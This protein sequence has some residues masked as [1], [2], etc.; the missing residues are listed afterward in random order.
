MSYTN[1][2]CGYFSF[3]EGFGRTLDVGG[4]FVEFNTSP[5]AAIADRVAIRSDWAAVG[6][7]LWAALLEAQKNL[8]GATGGTQQATKAIA[9]KA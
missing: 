2:L 7:D 5:T 3:W 8:P 6:A 9:E 4:T 1:S